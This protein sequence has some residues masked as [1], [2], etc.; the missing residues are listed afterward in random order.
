LHSN[1]V[2]AP[3]RAT[4]NNEAQ[5]GGY[6]AGCRPESTSAHGTEPDQAGIKKSNSK[7]QED[8]TLPV[9]RTKSGRVN[10]S[11]ELEEKS[12]DKENESSKKKNSEPAL[13]A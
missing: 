9:K 8:I 6:E 7:R 12:Y 3:A 5:S 11:F 13:L 4:Q 2:G 1:Q 10:L